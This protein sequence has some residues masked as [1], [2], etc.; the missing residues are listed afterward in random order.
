MTARQSRARTGEACQAPGTRPP[1]HFALPHRH[2]ATDRLNK[3][4]SARGPPFAD[5]Y[6]VRSRS[7]FEAPRSRSVSFSSSPVR[8]R[9]ADWPRGACPGLFLSA[10]IVPPQPA[11]RSRRAVGFAV[12]TAKRPVMNARPHARY[13]TDP[14]RCG[15]NAGVREDAGDAG[16]SD[17]SE[18]DIARARIGNHRSSERPRARE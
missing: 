14:Q 16:P 9:S 7:G 6:G 8:Q 2:L 12:D 1:L 4:G 10:R 13:A 17:N 5:L 11:D 3:Q 15:A 18:R